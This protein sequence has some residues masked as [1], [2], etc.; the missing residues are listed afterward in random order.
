MLREEFG[1]LRPWELTRFTPR[2]M[3]RLASY[4]DEV[5]ATVEEAEV[6]AKLAERLRDA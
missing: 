1:H 6:Q 4:V 3:T 2:E 5:R